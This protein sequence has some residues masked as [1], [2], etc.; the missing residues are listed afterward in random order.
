MK[1]E[2]VGEDESIPEE[3]IATFLNGNGNDKVH[4]ARFIDKNTI[5]YS[6]LN[7]R[8][9]VEVSHFTLKKENNVF[10]YYS[11]VFTRCN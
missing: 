6:V 3:T 7:I 1:Q 11:G 5:K 2:Q 8:D 9:N 4:N 10:V